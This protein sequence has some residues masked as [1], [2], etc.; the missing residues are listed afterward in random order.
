MTFARWVFR[1]AGIYG[2]LA[3]LPNLFL[4]KLANAAAP[5]AITHPE[6]YYGFLCSALVWQ[7]VFLLIGQDPARWRPLM[8]VAVL[9]KAAFFVPCLVLF[10]TGRLAMGG[11]MIGSLIDGVLLALFIAAWRASAPKP[12]AS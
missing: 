2:I 7:L 8:L 1:I 3:L 6:Y 4:E 12:A 10:F 11:P 5:P 9:E